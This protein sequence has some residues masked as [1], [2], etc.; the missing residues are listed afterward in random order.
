MVYLDKETIEAL[1]KYVNYCN[2]KEK[3]EKG[4]Y[5][6]AMEELTDE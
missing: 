5:Q 3:Y 1:I 6:G 4:D 2:A